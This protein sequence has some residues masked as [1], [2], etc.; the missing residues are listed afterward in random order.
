MQIFKVFLEG[1]FFDPRATFGRPRS[2]KG[3][4]KGAKMEAKA[5]LEA[6]AG[7]CKMHGR[8]GVFTH[9]GLS[10]RVREATFSKVGFQIHSGGVPG[11]IFADFLRF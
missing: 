2:R 9:S 6:L 11:S 3:S 10:G 5:G 1:L 4:R 7:K 8:R